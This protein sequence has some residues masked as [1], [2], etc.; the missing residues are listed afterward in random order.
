MIALLALYEDWFPFLLAAAYVVLHHGVM[1]AL[2]PG[3]CLQPPRRRGAP[4]EVGGDPRRLRRRGRHCER[5]RPGASTRTCAPRRRLAYRQARESEERFKSAFSDAPI[6]MVLESIEPA[7]AG[8]FLQVNQR[9]VRAS[10]GY[11]EEELIGKHF[12]DIT[13]PDDLDESVVLEQQLAGRG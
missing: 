6:G 4:L 1:G 8:R 2:D 3:A 13:Y 5:R 9:D 10:P 7:S 11:S 12:T